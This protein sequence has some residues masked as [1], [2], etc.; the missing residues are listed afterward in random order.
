MRISKLHLQNFRCYDDL[1]ID[2]HK[3]MTVIVGENG[4]GKT[5]ILDALAISMAPYLNAF[6]IRGRNMTEK[7]VRKI[8]DAGCL[9]K[10][11]ILRMKSKYPVEIKV[12]GESADGE[13]ISW[14]R[15]L[16]SSRGRTTSIHAKQLADYG[17]KLW[18][19]VNSSG[20]EK[21]V[22]PVLAYY[23]SPCNSGRQTDLAKRIRQTG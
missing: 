3:N 23:G 17:R 9:E 5:A 20:D 8:K 1:E 4:K 11:R 6:S 19:M 10:L 21:V 12:D 14:Q 16:K 18:D 7:D 22:L 2:F 15:E 13:Q